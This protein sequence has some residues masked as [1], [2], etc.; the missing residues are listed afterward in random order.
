VNGLHVENIHVTLI[1][2]SRD[3]GALVVF[4]QIYSARI[5]KSLTIQD[6]HRHVILA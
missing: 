1:E 2:V 3:V 6:L 5:G 4:K